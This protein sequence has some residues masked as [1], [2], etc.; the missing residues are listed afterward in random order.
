MEGLN[1][2]GGKK[3]EVPKMMGPS[4]HADIHKKIDTLHSQVDY[5]KDSLVQKDS[6]LN[7]MRNYF[8]QTKYYVEQLA[9]KITGIFSDLNERFS[10]LKENT[11]KINS[12]QSVLNDLQLVVKD[13]QVKMQD[14]PSSDELRVHIL[15]TKNEIVEELNVL[16]AQTKELKI[17]D[18]SLDELKEHVGSVK[19]DMLLE[20]DDLRK[21]LSKM[22]ADEGLKQADKAIAATKSIKTGSSS[23]KVQVKAPTK[24]KQVVKLKVNALSKPSVNKEI[25]NKVKVVN[26][27]PLVA[28]ELPS[29]EKVEPNEEEHYVEVTPVKAVPK[30]QEQIQEDSTEINDIPNEQYDELVSINKML[31]EA[32]DYLEAGDKAKAK[33]LYKNIYSAYLNIRSKHSPETEKMFNRITYLYKLIKE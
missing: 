9:T 8:D 31:S 19:N 12:L 15:S 18:R 1:L 20:I 6:E 11:E 17:D 2:G 7:D 25:G 22:G 4:D 28:P 32:V 16:K 14:V 29:E 24:E 13:H 5:L 33:A 21:K 23:K 10:D 30:V 27:K 26:K 3:I